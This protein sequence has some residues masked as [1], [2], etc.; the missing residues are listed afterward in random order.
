M[1]KTLQLK[2]YL[3]GSNR[4]NLFPSFNPRFSTTNVQKL[5]TASSSKKDQMLN[6]NNLMNKNVLKALFLSYI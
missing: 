1:L 5:F 3:A 2:L 4:E 6:W